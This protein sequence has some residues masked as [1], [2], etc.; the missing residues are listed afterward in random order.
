MAQGPL[1]INK[2]SYGDHLSLHE[3]GDVRA[4]Q[5]LHYLNQ[6]GGEITEDLTGIQS[7]LE[8]I[9]RTAVTKGQLIFGS[10]LRADAQKL[11]GSP[12]KTFGSPNHVK[13][14][15]AQISLQ[16]DEITKKEEIITQLTNELDDLRT[17]HSQEI[18]H[19]NQ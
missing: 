6:H 8:Q 1:N 19:L 18:N 4:Q 15:E 2:A 7:K 12:G 10:L 16:D 13:K 5:I 9:I 11:P 14:L 3:V 17:Q